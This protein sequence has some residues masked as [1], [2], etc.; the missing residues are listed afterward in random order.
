MVK[1]TVVGLR[2]ELNLL[3]KCTGHNCDF[4]YYKEMGNI[5]I[6]LLKCDGALYELTLYIEEGECGSG[7][8]T[9]SYGRSSMKRVS[10]FAGKTHK[11]IS[12]NEIELSSGYCGIED[13]ENMYFNFS[14]NGDDYYYPRGYVNVHMDQFKILNEYRI[15]DRPIWIITGCSETRD[16]LSAFDND[17]SIYYTESKKDLPDEIT[18]SIIVVGNNHKLDDVEQRIF[19]RNNCCIIYI[20][21][22]VGNE[23]DRL[24][25]EIDHTKYMPPP[26]TDVEPESLASCVSTHSTVETNNNAEPCFIFNGPSLTGKSYLSAKLSND[27]SVYE[28]DKIQNL[29]EIITESIIVVGCKYNH[30][31]KEIEQRADPHNRSNF[32][33][34][35]FSKDESTFDKI[36]QLKQELADLQQRGQYTGYEDARC[37]FETLSKD[38]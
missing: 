15:L 33:Y 3:R 20:H 6:I 11:P 31:L 24:L 19:D 14:E 2:V 8:T 9:A 21:C 12:Q 27:F 34:L 18:D 16:L 26:Q 5:Y 17:L 13:T 7:W 23:I 4:T 22:T 32:I 36:E 29:P 25:M 28:T 38:V 10:H 30:Q 35:Y 37:S 1:Y